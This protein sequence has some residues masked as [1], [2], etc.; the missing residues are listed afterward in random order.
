MIEIKNTKNIGR[1]VFATIDIKKGTIIHISPVI[2]IKGKELKSLES[3]IIDHY[4]FGWNKTTNALALGYG[5]LFN[6][7]SFANVTYIL[8]KKKLTITFKA[9]K[10]VSAGEQLFINYGYNPL[11]YLRKKKC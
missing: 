10:N 9:V 1:G 5:S 2:L 7:R 8:N 11:E 4:V 6:H 3:T